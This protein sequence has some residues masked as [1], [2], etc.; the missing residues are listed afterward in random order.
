MDH[1]FLSDNTIN[2]LDENLINYNKKI[3]KYLKIIKNYQYQINLYRK[4]VIDLKLETNKLQIIYTEYNKK[5]EKIENYICKVCFE[6]YC[7]CIIIPCMHFISCE[8]C[9]QK[10]N[11]NMCPIC[12]TKFDKYVRVFI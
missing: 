9:L 5:I 1:I 11:N 12:R 10:L 2:T 7:D 3:Y 4:L 8:K 6:S